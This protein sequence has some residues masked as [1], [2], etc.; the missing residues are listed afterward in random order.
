M[1]R[2]S[3][4]VAVEG[5]TQSIKALSSASKEAGAEAKGLIRTEAKHIQRKAQGKM[6]RRSG[7]GSYPR[8]KGAIRYGA[9][10]KG[11]TISITAGKG[12]RYPWIFGAEFG[13]K[14][15]W[16]YGRVTTQGR[17]KR[18]QFPVWRGNRFVVRGGSGPGW[19]VQPAIREELP[20]VTRRIEAG[21]SELIA[22]ELARARVPRSV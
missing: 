6:A 16:V 4:A 17:L 11:G 15:A 3:D 21:M 2:Q 22:R 12:D 8:R 19:L 10:Q 14:R 7:G 20:G 9:T 5:L 13:A 1:D 18:R